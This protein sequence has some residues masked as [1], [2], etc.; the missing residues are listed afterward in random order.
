MSS[1]SNSTSSSS[2]SRS[3]R[4]HNTSSPSGFNS[5][6]DLVNRLNE[7]LEE[8]ES[9]RVSEGEGSSSDASTSDQGNGYPSK[10]TE[11]YFDPF[12][13]RYNIP[14]S[15]GLRLPLE[16]E[17]TDNPPD[18]CVTLYLKMFEFRFRLPLHPLAQEFFSRVGF[19]PSYRP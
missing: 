18:G 1:S 9:F 14:D 19:A 5:S 11:N 17:T 8:V 13:R 16:G 4:N 6:K 12:R 10:M 15:I 3:G 7:E 2:S